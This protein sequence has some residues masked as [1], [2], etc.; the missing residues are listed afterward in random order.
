MLRRNPAHLCGYVTRGEF[1]PTRDLIGRFRLGLTKMDRAL[2][3]SLFYA[4]RNQSTQQI[5]KHRRVS[6]TSRRGRRFG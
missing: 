6:H 2:H 3:V 4:N 5:V 1:F